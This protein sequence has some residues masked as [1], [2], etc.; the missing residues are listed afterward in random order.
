MRQY[1]QRYPSV[2][3]QV[4]AILFSNNNNNAFLLIQMP[5]FPQREVDFFRIRNPV[6]VFFNFIKLILPGLGFEPVTSSK[7][8]PLGLQVVNAL[9]FSAI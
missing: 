6:G 8:M 2:G 4:L 9:A 3:C 1:H 5:F 7:S